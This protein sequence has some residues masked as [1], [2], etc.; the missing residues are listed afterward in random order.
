MAVTKKCVQ[1]C[2]CWYC[3]PILALQ[4]CCETDFNNNT[5]TNNNIL[6]YSAVVFEMH[7]N[8]TIVTVAS[9]YILLPWYTAVKLCRQMPT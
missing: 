8:E 3:R 7:R 6:S 9:V 1:I 2:L 5:T 4:F